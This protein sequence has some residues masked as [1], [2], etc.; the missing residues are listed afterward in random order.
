V[1]TIEVDEFKFLEVSTNPNI[2]ISLKGEKNFCELN[3]SDK[4]N[5]LKTNFGLYRYS[6]FEQVHGVLID[7]LDTSEKNEFDGFIT[8]EKNHAFAIKTADC[9]P[10]VMWDD[11]EELLCGLHCGWKGLQQGIIGKALEKNK[12]QN[13]TKSYI[14]PHISKNYFEVKQDLINKFLQVDCDIEPFLTRIG[15]KIFMDLRHFCVDE[16]HEYGVEIFTN[17]SPC[18]YTEIDHFFS[19]RRDPGNPLRNL[20]IAWL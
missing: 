12:Y 9:I 18:S 13:L 15:G 16:L 10:L 14:G 2:L 3:L 1:N 20:T 11:K 7:G 8:K 6:E 4:S 17:F 5:F 19:W